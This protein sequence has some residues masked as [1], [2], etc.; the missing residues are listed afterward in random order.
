MRRNPRFG[1]LSPL[2]ALVML[3]VN[4][5]VDSV[6]PVKSGKELGGRPFK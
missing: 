6:V 1:I 5:V 2:I 3:Y 4:L